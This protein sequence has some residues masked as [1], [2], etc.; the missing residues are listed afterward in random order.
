GLGGFNRLNISFQHD[1]MHRVLEAQTREPSAMQL[2]P[3]R[4]ARND[5]PGAT[6]SPR[7][8]GVPD[9]V[10]APRR[11]GRAPDRASPR[12]AHPEPTPR[13]ARPPAAAAPDWPHPAD[14]S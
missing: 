6:E 1:V 8:A 14:P 12:A 11:D 10:H 3:R 9:A 13:S 2:G 7:A 4:G 5:S